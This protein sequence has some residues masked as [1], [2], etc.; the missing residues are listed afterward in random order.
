M[1]LETSFGR[2]LQQR[3]RALDL[4]Q[5]E[6]ARQVGCATVT[7]HKLELEERRPSKEIAARLAECLQIPDEDRSAFL[8]FARGESSTKIPAPP[9][10][11]DDPAPWRRSMRPRTNLPTPSTPLI[12]REQEL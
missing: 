4:T 10:A 11:R 8:A 3:R 9:P 6:L 12:G 5:A 1:T 7:I 2:W